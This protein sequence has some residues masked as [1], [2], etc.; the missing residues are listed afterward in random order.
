M[1]GVVQTASDALADWC[2]LGVEAFGMIY[3]EIIA[4]TTAKPWA[5]LAVDPASKPEAAE[6]Q[7]TLVRNACSEAQSSDV[8]VELALRVTS[9]EVNVRGRPQEE[10]DAIVAKILRD[11]S[12]ARGR[13]QRLMQDGALLT[14]ETL[15][16]VLKVDDAT[17]L[18][19]RNGKV[20][21]TAFLVGVDLVLTSAHVVMADDGVA[22]LDKLA[23]NLSFSFLVPP[24][25][26]NRKPVTAAPNSRNPLEAWSLPWGRPP[27]RL[28]MPPDVGSPTRLDYALI[29]LDRQISHLRPLALD[30]PPDP[31]TT[32]ALVVLGFAGGT[33]MKWGV[34]PV[35]AVKSERLLHKASTLPGMSG[36]C[37]INVHGAPI[38]L[39][40]GSIDDGKFAFGSGSKNG[41]NRAVCLSVI[42]QAMQANGSDPLVARPRSPGYAILDESLVR[43]WANAGLRLA[44][45]EATR[46]WWRDQVKEAIGLDPQDADVFPQFH[47]WFQRKP[48]EDWVDK[49]VKGDSSDRL[50]V[51]TGTPGSGKSF[52]AA[53]L[54]AKLG[55]PD[56]DLVVIPATQTTAWSWNDALVKLG[57]TRG[58]EQELRPE[59]G[60]LRHVEVPQAAK[61][62]ASRNGRNAHTESAPLFV[63]ID[64]EG[65]PALNEEESPWLLFMQELLTMSWVRL[66]VIN[67]PQT[68]TE[69]VATLAFEQGNEKYQVT[70][71]ELKQ[72]GSVEFRQFANQLLS[73]ADQ[74]KLNKAMQIRTLILTTNPPLPQELLTVSSV[75][76]GIMLE[77]N[78]EP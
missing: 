7:K 35:T 14:R 72:I 39:H 71:V 17:A 55:N 18:V 41:A 25:A 23:M 61:E 62:V 11:P 37:C 20:V 13:M 43:M 16:G 34:G 70:Y 10:A 68:L 53:I 73:N 51:V 42:R 26:T 27:D 4:G 36:S 12:S 2:K 65:A 28:L 5:I 77:R 6:G 30:L 69:T 63:V 33:A 54:R 60:R 29:R 52:L 56:T 67:A 74:Q 9:A 50:C 15:E 58:R 22:F 49:S 31:E 24:G 47:P 38:A 48:F 8:L 32:D 76:A 78:Q 40:E 1:N 57:G 19:Y 21:G 44:Q 46:D 3:S 75:L 64:F 45:Q 66:V 59:S